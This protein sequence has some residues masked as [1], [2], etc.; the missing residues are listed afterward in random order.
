MTDQCLVIPATTCQVDFGLETSSWAPALLRSGQEQI[1]TL[2]LFDFTANMTRA[3]VEVDEWV[4][5]EKGAG[6]NLMLPRA[7]FFEEL[8]DQPLIPANLWTRITNIA[9]T[10]Q[11][12]QLASEAHTHSLSAL[13]DV[14][15]KE[16]AETIVRDCAI[17]SLINR[18]KDSFHLLNQAANELT[19]RWLAA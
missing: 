18:S 7:T 12:C 10:L 9:Q 13:M 8:L 19:S 2:A 4:P 15:S 17:N 6:L 3:L 14:D 1:K 11:P 5:V 16:G